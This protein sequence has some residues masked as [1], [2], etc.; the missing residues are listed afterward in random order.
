MSEYTK[1]AKELL[2]HAGEGRGDAGWGGLEDAIKGY[3]FATLALAEQ[4]RIANLIA[5]GILDVDEIPETG[6]R[7]LLYRP[8]DDVRSCPDIAATLG[9]GDGDE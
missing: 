2:T 1:K 4:Q 8:P 5:L 7:G 6:E 3:G 9:I